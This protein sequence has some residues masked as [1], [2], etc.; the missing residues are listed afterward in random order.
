MF[1][2]F[3]ELQDKIL[4]IVARSEAFLLD[5]TRRDV[6]GLGR[7]RWDLARTLREYQSLIFTQI[8]DRYEH[9]ADQAGQLARQMKNDCI[10]A[11]EDFRQYVLKW[12][13]ISILDHW[14]DYRPAALEAIAKVR[15]QLAKERAGVTDLLRV[16]ALAA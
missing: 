15:S 7:T 14:D 10:R 13:V 12:S 9:R 8:F 4:A 11:G 5:E 1:D 3:V 2:Q 6:G 16:S